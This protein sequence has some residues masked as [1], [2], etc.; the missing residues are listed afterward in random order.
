[1][2]VKCRAVSTPGTSE[3]GG[4]VPKATDWDRSWPPAKWPHHQLILNRLLFVYTDKLRPATHGA[5][6]ECQQRAEREH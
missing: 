6:G 3:A 5:A 4:S 1:M 2:L